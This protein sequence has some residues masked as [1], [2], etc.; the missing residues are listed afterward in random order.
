M[1]ILWHQQIILM[2]YMQTKH[3]NLET[4]VTKNTTLL[5]YIIIFLR[6]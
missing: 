4:T 5:Q 1:E 3:G 6:A 2:Y